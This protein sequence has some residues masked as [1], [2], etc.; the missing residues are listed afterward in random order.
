M[1]VLMKK[2][3]PIN[4]NQFVWLRWNVMA[5][6]HWIM[7]MRAWMWI[8]FIDFYTQIKPLAITMKCLASF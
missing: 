3:Y 2:K 4:L 6:E 5:Q 7:Q 1:K 8:I